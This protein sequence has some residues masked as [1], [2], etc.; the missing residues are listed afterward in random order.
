MKFAFPAVK[1]VGDVIYG[2]GSL[3]SSLATDTLADTVVF[4]SSNQTVRDYLDKGFK[5]NGQSFDVA[6]CVI[7]P[8]GEPD[9]V[10]INAGADVIRTRRPS[11]ILAIGG[12]S[13]LDLARLC[14]AQAT[15]SLDISTGRVLAHPENEIKPKITLV[16]TTCGT[17]AEAATVAV[18]SNSNGKV[19]SVSPEFLADRVILD[20]KFLGSLSESEL[21]GFLSDALSHAIE[22]NLSI[23]PAGFAKIFGVSCMQMI[24]SAY[25]DQPGAARNDR[26]MQAG[27]LGGVAASHCSVGI[28][29]AF[30]HAL[31]RFGVSHALGN[32]Y[33]LAAGIRVNKDTPQMHRLLADANMQDIEHL[34]S[35][36]RQVTTT[37][38]SGNTEMRELLANQE[39]RRALHAAMQVD[40]AA[41]SNPLPVNEET[42]NLFL[43]FVEEE[44]LRQ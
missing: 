33:G 13:V 35:V 9:V 21:S 41:R 30:S 8:P 1:Q 42:A 26:L 34:L 18:F 24:F 39:Q 37:A 17:G 3:S 16:P 4:L 32:A 38:T 23:V 19:A 25:A 11:S 27:F 15:N 43:D 12:G 14:W 7:K 20:G 31:S 22:S 44:S 2:S 28:I 5:K 10:M 29:H 36:V 6:Q 40:V